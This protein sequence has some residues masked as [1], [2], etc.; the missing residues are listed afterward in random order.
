MEDRHAKFFPAMAVVCSAQAGRDVLLVPH[1]RRCDRRP[2]SAVRI[3]GH[4]VRNEPGV[5]QARTLAFF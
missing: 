5:E 4:V 3:C 2:D 1:V